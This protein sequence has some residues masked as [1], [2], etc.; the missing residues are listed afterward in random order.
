MGASVENPPSVGPDLAVAVAQLRLAADA[1]KCWACGCLRHALE[2]IDRAL[3][4]ASRSE[5]LTSAV[6]AA[7]AALQ[8]QRYDCLGCDV[9]YPPLALNALGDLIDQGGDAAACP[10]ERV[11]E[12]AGWPPLPGS[13]RVLRY[14]APVAVCTL[15]DES[16]AEQVARAE[17]PGLAI[18]GSMHTENLGIERL[19]TNVLANPS[20]RFVV[21]CGPDSRQ[22]IGHLP[23]QSLLALSRAGVDARQRIIGAHG[24]RPVLRNLEAAAIAHFRRT[25]E[26]VDLIGNGDV[27][28]IAAA[29]RDCTGRDLGPAEAFAPSRVITPI[30]GSIPERMV[31]DPAGYFVIFVDRARRRLCLEHYAN[32][33]VLTTVIEGS[34]AA[35]LYTPAIERDLVSR[36]DHAAYLGRELARA[37][38]AI[39]SGEPYVQDAAPERASIGGCGCGSGG[40]CSGS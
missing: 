21:A 18:V 17:L 28:K 39:A 26:V 29:I 25:V 5:E 11:E 23:G 20:I 16:L 13:Y 38:Q 8:P 3:P 40:S 1:R 33:G 37:E 4:E 7:R 19:M 27:E 36:L 34:T 9:C 2:A 10:T 30:S 6:A 24:K 12:R 31:S 22:R 35:E 15:N 32:S 14:R